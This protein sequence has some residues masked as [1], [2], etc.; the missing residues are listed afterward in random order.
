MKLNTSSIQRFFQMEAAGGIL[1]IVAALVAIL[2]ANSPLEPFY[3]LL[4][5]TPVEITIGEFSID[6][7]LLLWINDGLMAVFFFMIGLELKREMMEGELSSPSQVIL[8]GIGAIGGM[9]FP[10]L[11]YVAFN[12]DQPQALQGWA[13]P[14]ATDI[15]F[16]LGVLSLLGPSVPRAA[17]VFLASLAI[18]DDVGA[19]IIIAVFYTDNISMLA[20]SVAGSC[21][22]VL[23]LMK[24]AGVEH[25]RAYFLV[26]LV[27]WA[28]M[29]KS[30]VHA[31]LAGVLLA[32]FIPMQSRKHPGRSPLR[33]LEHGIHPIVT[34]MILPVFAFANAGVT[35]GATGSQYLLHGVPVGIALGLFLGNQLGIFSLCWLA[36][37]LGWTQLPKDMNWLM[38]YGVA[39]LCGIGFTMSLFI[40]SLAFEQSG[41]D[42]F[43]D[44]RIGILAGSLMSGV[45][46]YLVLRYA[47]RKRAE[48]T[49]ILA[50][51]EGYPNGVTR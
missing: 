10:A 42:R 33:E 11:I 47:L 8:P 51:H 40:G 27:M 43:F 30:G 14:S 37:R 35:F 18:F 29:L 44:E 1:L 21:L 32:M 7:P 13:I 25:R 24:L 3:A 28:S 4:L 31:T 12:W 2:L 50:G 48:A 15:A 49:S 23:S 26:G 46:G 34:F 16:A 36:V 5:Q 38:L 17:K 6:K 45:A 19:I 20:L 41:I 22:L 39:M 9:L